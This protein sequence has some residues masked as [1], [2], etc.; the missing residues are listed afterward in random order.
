MWVGRAIWVARLKISSCPRVSFGDAARDLEGV[1]LPLVKA[2]N[3]QH[4]AF[5]QSLDLLPNKAEGIAFSLFPLG[6][7]SMKWSKIGIFEPFLRHIAG[8][9]RYQ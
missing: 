3:S 7:N 8:S 2:C 6:G 1:T 5:G 9:V 4:L